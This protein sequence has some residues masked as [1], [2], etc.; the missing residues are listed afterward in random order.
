M[1]YYTECPTC[2]A[3]LDPGEMCDCGGKEDFRGWEREKQYHEKS[4]LVFMKNTEAVAL[5][6]ASR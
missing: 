1:A 4:E 5:I 6:A 2:G 3:H